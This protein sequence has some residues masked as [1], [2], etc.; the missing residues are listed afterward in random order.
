MNFL[1]V[2]VTPFPKCKPQPT[3]SLRETLEDTVVRVLGRSLWTFILDTFTSRGGLLG[4]AACTVQGGM[5]E[6]MVMSILM[7]NVFG[8][9]ETSA[10]VALLISEMGSI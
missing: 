9:A 6:V 10:V 4:R 3:T 7:T 1:L 8:E 2:V 5:R